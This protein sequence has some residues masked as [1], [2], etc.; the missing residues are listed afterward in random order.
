MHDRKGRVPVVR[1]DHVGTGAVPGVSED[2]R[3]DRE[4]GP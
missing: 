1:V 3:G 2:T 4:G